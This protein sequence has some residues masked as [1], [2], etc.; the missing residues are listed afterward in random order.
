MAKSGL[1]VLGIGHSDKGNT[2]YCV[3]PVLS[4]N[5]QGIA[6]AGNHDC[7]CAVVSTLDAQLDNA[8]HDGADECREVF[9]GL[10]DLNVSAPYAHGNHIHGVDDLFGC[11]YRSGQNDLAAFCQVFVHQ[12]PGACCSLM[13]ASE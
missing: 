13:E 10:V 7:G 8:L 2:L 5:L 4:D 12:L 11:V 1:S 6:K 9:F 3:F